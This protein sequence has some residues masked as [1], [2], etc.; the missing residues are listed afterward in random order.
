V[1]KPQFAAYSENFGPVCEF[2]WIRLESLFD[3]FKG[4]DK[5]TCAFLR[6][7]QASNKAADVSRR[8]GFEQTIYS[9]A[10]QDN[11][12]AWTA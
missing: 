3:R 10:N 4:I 12:F 7:C 6:C 5:G 2:L 11:T 1:F 8:A 9:L